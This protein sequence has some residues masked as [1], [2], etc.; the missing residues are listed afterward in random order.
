MLD[1]SPQQHYRLVTFDIGGV[2]IRICHTW[3]A[4]AKVAGVKTRLPAD[5]AT[6]LTDLPVFDEY[7]MGAVSLEEY[8]RKVAEWLECDVAGAE[9]IHNGILIEPY[10]GTEELV[11]ELQAAGIC[12]ACLSNT[13]EPHWHE[14]FSGRFPAVARLDRKMASHLVGINKPDPKIFR[15]HAEINHVAPEEVIYFDDHPLNAQSAAE[16]GFHTL[17]IDPN[18]DTVAQMRGFLRSSGVLP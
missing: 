6:P 18:G 13:N 7:Q 9:R 10:P 5:G 2:L 4:A 14:F 8:L 3:E 1:L 17:R 12:T 15:L 11:A 16:V